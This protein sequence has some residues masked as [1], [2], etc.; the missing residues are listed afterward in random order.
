M[1]DLDPNF[2]PL[3][4]FD[5]FGHRLQQRIALAADVAGIDAAVTRRR[6]HQTDHLCR[7][8]IETR[9]VEQAG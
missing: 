6:P 3:A 2:R 9:R 1:G 7:L 5:G 8:G 4:D